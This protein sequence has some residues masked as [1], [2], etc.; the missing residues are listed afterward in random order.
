MNANK[1]DECDLKW[2]SIFNKI[3]CCRFRILY[4]LQGWSRKRTIIDVYVEASSCSVREV[5]S[6]QKWSGSSEQLLWSEIHHK[7]G[8]L[9]LSSSLTWWGTNP[10]TS[11]SFPA[12]IYGSCAREGQKEM[13]TVFKK[14]FVIV[15]K[16]LNVVVIQFQ[17]FVLWTMM[18]K[19]K[20]LSVNLYSV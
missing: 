10:T 16:R 9:W 5:V 11:E 8:S 15:D 20:S 6:L 4:F 3:T 2:R 19:Y 13:C 1:G 17:T 14:V 7:P 12:Y 18:P